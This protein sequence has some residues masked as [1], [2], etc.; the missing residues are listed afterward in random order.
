M[1]SSSG[2]MLERDDGNAIWFLGT[3]MTVKAAGAATG[4]ALTLIECEC[5]AGFATPPHIHR[6]EDEAFYVLAGSIRVTCGSAT[7]RVRPG[8]FVFLPKGTPHSFVVSDVEPASMLQL[9]AP[10]QFEHFAAEAGDA[11]TR[12]GL[13]D[14][15]EPDI[16]R[17]LAAASRYDIEIL[18]PPVG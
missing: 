17:L 3:R 2:Y 18:P 12:S 6:V 4:G 14:P 7:W 5:P 8:G 15:G 1:T 11:A 13:P 10:S 9:T 16:E